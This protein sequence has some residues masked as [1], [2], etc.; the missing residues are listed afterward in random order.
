MICEGKGPELMWSEWNGRVDGKGYFPQEK[1]LSETANTREPE[2]NLISPFLIF[3]KVI[4]NKVA[5]FVFI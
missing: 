5:Q 1:G 2:E 3:E 4:K